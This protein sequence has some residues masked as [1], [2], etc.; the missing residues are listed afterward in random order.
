MDRPLVRAAATML[1]S[2]W[3]NYEYSIDGLK[4]N[5]IPTF[6]F[7]SLYPV[8]KGPAKGGILECIIVAPLALAVF[9]TIYIC[10][11]VCSQA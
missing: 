1:D 10:E 3:N 11:T 5:M 8:G 2:G 9:L 6:A 4:T 7:H